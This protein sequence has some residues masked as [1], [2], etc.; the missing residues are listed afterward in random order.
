SGGIAY[1]F[2]EGANFA[3]LCNREMVRLGTLDETSEIEFVR[4][5]IERHVDLTGSGIGRRILDDWENQ[6]GNFV[7][8]I[9]A[10][11]EKIVSAQER[12]LTAG[13]SKDEA[14][15]SAFMEATG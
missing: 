11:Y 12:F 8:V 13:F 6:R 5:M 4:R 9:P 1:V 7:R 2:D 15:M 10:D 14:A 3:A